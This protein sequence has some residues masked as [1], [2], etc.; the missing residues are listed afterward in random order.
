MAKVDEYENG[1]YVMTVQLDEF[2]KGLKPEENDAFEALKGVYACVCNGITK[3][4][5]KFTQAPQFS[6]EFE[7]ADVLDGNGQVGRKL[8]RR[9]NLDEK[10]I[11]DLVDDLF[12][13]GVE[14]SKDSVEALEASLD[15]A[16]GKTFY[17]RAWGWTP[18]KTKDGQDI[19]ES[20]RKTMQQ[21]SVMSEKRATKLAAKK[22][23]EL[24]F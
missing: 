8:W 3:G 6:A 14:F 23:G 5:N 17:L 15:M 16:K 24:A 13:A 12:T 4:E 18:E 1:G 9:Y 22:K 2:L 20:D 7:V 21:F 10:G 19:P 11:K